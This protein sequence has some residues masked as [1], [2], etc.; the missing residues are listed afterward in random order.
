MEKLTERVLIALQHPNIH[1]ISHPTG[2]L[3]GEREGYDLDWEKVFNAA[4]TSGKVL[5]VDGFPNRSDLPDQLIREAVKRK[6]KLA[7]DTDAHDASHL[8][9]MKFAVALAR[10]GW[11]TKDLVINSWDLDKLLVYISKDKIKQ[12]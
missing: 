5:E 7:V 1:M 11:A 3:L 6:I 2:R 12:I 9:L 8:R 4:E 10:R